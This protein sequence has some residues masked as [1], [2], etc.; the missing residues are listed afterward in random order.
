MC[1]GRVDL[2]YILRAFSKGAD[3]V[4]IVG[5][6]LNECNYITHGNFH[7]LSMVHLSKKIMEQIGLN[8]ERL[9]IEFMSGG[10]GIF[11]AE[12]MNDFGKKV[13]EIGPIGQSEGIDE[14]TLKTKL[15]AVTRLVPYIRLVE[16]ERLRVRFDTEKEYD[17]FFSSDEV[18]RLF[19]ELIADKLAVSQMMLLLRE[20]PLSAGEISGFLGLNPSE[21]SRHLNSSARQGL[22]RFDE[23]QRCFAPA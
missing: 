14:K 3:G 17:D 16:R 13:K 21:V 20:R 11:F 15:E 18:D 9:M 8:R 5:C 23:G 1:T 7:A 22:V 10:E 19:S 12:V 2:S 4:F 6:R